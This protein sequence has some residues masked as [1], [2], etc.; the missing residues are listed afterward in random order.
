MTSRPVAVCLFVCVTALLTFSA[1]ASAKRVTGHFAR[2]N[3]QCSFAGTKEVRYG[4]NGSYFYRTLSNGTACTN[5]CSATLP[6]YLKTA[7]PGRVTG[8]SARGKAG[9]AH[10]PAPR[11]CAMART[12]CTT[13]KPYLAGRPA[14][15]AYSGIQRWY[16]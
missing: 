13:T 16:G 8:P 2:G 11:R 5:R 15:I 1:S 9:S 10:L 7:P 3:T 6:R 4:A 12:G 14:R